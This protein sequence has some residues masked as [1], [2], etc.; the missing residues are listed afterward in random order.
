MEGPRVTGDQEPAEAR[1]QN[2]MRWMSGLR[3]CVKWVQATE[4]HQGWF[5]DLVVRLRDDTYVFGP[6]LLTP[7]KYKGAFVTAQIASNFGV[8]DHNFVVDRYWADPVLRGLTEDY[9][10]NETL[11][12]RKWLNPEHRIYDVAR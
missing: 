11:D 1:F 3:D 10:F 7:E 2:N 12:D 4:H 9:Y 6:W 8:N 5:Y